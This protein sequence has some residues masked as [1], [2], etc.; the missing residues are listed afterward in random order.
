MGLQ[1]KVRWVHCFGPEVRQHFLVV[2]AVTHLLA[3]GT[4]VRKRQG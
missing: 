2:G 3:P 1:F 4:K